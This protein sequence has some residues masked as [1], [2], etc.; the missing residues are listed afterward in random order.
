MVPVQA[1]RDEVL[2]QFVPQ[3]GRWVPIHQTVEVPD[4]A[5]RSSATVAR[6]AEPVDQGEVDRQGSKRVKLALLSYVWLSTRALPHRSGLRPRPGAVDGIAGT[7]RRRGGPPPPI[8]ENL[9]ALLSRV[10]V[11][12]C[13]VVLAR[14]HRRS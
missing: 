11:E 12:P 5:T 1:A 10:W 13:G 3:A 9:T 2:A 4:T 8:K 7:V 6:I 14:C